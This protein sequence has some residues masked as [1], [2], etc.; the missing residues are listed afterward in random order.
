[1]L[2]PRAYRAGDRLAL[3]VS[4]SNAIPLGIGGAYHRGRTEWIAEVSADVLVGSAAPS[5]AESPWRVG[6]GARHSLSEAVALT[7]MAEASLS[8]RPPT[9][10]SDPFTPVEPRFQMLVGVAYT[11]LDWEPSA[12]VPSSAP[13]PEPAPVTTAAP[14]PAPPAPATSL[15]VNVTT[16]D[17]YPLSDAVVELRM[18]ETIIAIPHRNLESYVLSEPP[19]GEATLRVSAPRLKPQTQS[20]RLQS[21]APLVVDVELEAAPQSGQLEGMVRSFGGQGLQARIR[22]EPAGIEL[23]TEGTGTFSVDIAPGRYEV[24]IEAP[25]HESQRRQVDIG[26]DGVVVLNADLSKAAQ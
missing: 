20:I 18:G 11:F 3:G 6:G 5:W 1:M 8:A 14:V 10:P 24:I 2:D 4:E 9:G 22:I 23:S 17:G 26:P 15:L 16:K 25:G 21:G 7:W 13:A 12:P 19:S